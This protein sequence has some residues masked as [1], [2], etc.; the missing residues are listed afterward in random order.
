V[1]RRQVQ[2]AEQFVIQAGQ[3]ATLM[4]AP[5]SLTLETKHSK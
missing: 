2:T 4:E 1:T 5:S 3:G